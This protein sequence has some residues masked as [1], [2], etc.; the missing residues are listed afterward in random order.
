MKTRI[1]LLT[2]VSLVVGFVI[3]MSVSGYLNRQKVNKWREGSSPQGMY[4]KWVDLLQPRPDQADA[5]EV[6]LKEYIRKSSVS[7]S[8]SFMEQGVLFREMES[9]IDPLLD[10]GQI[11]RKE[12][13]KQKFR[14]W[15]KSFNKKSGDSLRPDWQKSDT[16]TKAEE[17]QKPDSVV[18]IE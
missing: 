6:L 8:K 15:E 9:Q 5:L 2:F 14:K 16:V 11:Q 3:G 4:Q 18:V 13:F 1:I 12:E 10:S 17:T 7:M